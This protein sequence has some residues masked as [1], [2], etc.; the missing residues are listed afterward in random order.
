VDDPQAE[1]AYTQALVALMRQV[2]RD[3]RAPGRYEIMMTV[4]NE[5]GAP[6]RF[7]LTRLETIRVFE[8]AS[9]KPAG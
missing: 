6:H 1:L 4:P 8:H 7:S 3:C 9:R 2:A 5:P